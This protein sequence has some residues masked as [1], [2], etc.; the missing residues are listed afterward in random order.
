MRQLQL[1]EYETSQPIALDTQQVATLQRTK[2]VRV[3][4]AD[5]AMDLWLVT[6]DHHVGVVQV[7][8]LEVRIQPKVPVSRLLFMLGYAE[9]GHGWLDATIDTGE[10]DGLV[11][12]AAR[13]FV[14]HSNRALERGV[15]QGYVRR[16]E[17]TTSLRGRIR[18]ADQLQRRLG[19][20][21]PLEVTFDDFTVDIAENQL[22]RTAARALLLL[23]GVPERVRQRLL[24]LLTQL[25]GIGDL[26]IGEPL[27]QVAFTR[28]NERYRPAIGLAKL[29]LRSLSIEF[30][31]GKRPGLSFLFDM[32]QVFEAFVTS[33]LRN[34]LGP[35]GGE[36]R[37]QHHDWLDELGRIRIKPDISWWDAGQCL[38]VADAKYKNTGSLAGN[39]DIYQLVAYC[40]A[41]R[42]TPG[43]LLYAA[44][45]Q[46]VTTHVIRNGPIEVVVVALDL[47]LHPQRILD[48]LAALATAM[49][50]RVGTY[51]RPDLQAGTVQVWPGA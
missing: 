50:A 33:A 25:E 11:E 30:A 24:R 36:V 17:A 37:G 42:V 12:L 47:S 39:A 6:A 1:V 32:N 28:L 8:D 4:P 20:P 34:A 38:L 5:G 21:V 2:A 10:A 27:P 35:Y 51:Q 15:L 13:A 3:A 49:A 16:D 40:T 22:L 19:M 9:D 26:R 31:I 48:E 41:L 23:S 18:F 43:Y 44:G 14:W 46:E 45:Q 7:P 29:V